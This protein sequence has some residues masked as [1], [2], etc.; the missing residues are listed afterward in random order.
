M[1]QRLGARPIPT[2]GRPETTAVLVERGV[3][4]ER[5][6]VRDPSRF[7]DQLDAA[8]H[9]AGGPDLDVVFDAIGGPYFLP[10]LGRLRPEGRY[11]LYGAADFMPS[12]SRPNWPRLAWQYLRRPRLDPMRLIDRNR[13]VLGFNLIWLFEAAHRLP[14]AFAGALASSSDRPL[15]GLRVAFD[16]LPRGMRALQGGTTTGKVV[17]SLDG[18]RDRLS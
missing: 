3:P 16:D 1:I 7:S 5:I 18:D 17:V 15:I 8:I 13:G 2:V 12:G 11:L 9:A 10:A 14:A 6:I 4:R